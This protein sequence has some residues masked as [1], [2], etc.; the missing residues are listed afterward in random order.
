MT[1]GIGNPVFVVQVDHGGGFRMLSLNRSHEEA[2]GLSHVRMSGRPLNEVLPSEVVE[3]VT[4]HYQQCVERRDR[5]V[6]EELLVLPSGR[7]WWKTV[8]TPVLDEV[9]QVCRL[10]GSGTEVTELRHAEERYRALFEPNPDAVYVIDAESRFHACNPATER[11]SGYPRDE[12]LGKSFLDLVPKE[13]HER[14]VEAFAAV[15]GG[16]SFSLPLR[17]YRPDGELRYIDVTAA[18]YAMDGEVMGVMSIARDATDRIRLEEALKDS[19]RH[20]RTIADNLPIMITHFD[21]EECYTFNNHLYETA[22]NIPPDAMVGR[23]IEEIVPPAQYRQ[24]QPYIRRALEGEQ[25]SV[26]LEVELDTVGRREVEVTYLPDITEDGVLRGAFGM[27][28]DIS[29]RKSR[30]RLLTD[31]ATRDELTG[32]LNRAGLLQRLRRRTHEAPEQVNALL[33]L[34]LD[35]FKPVNDTYGHSAGDRLLRIIAERL[36]GAVRVGDDVARL[37]GDE[38]V[39]LLSGVHDEAQVAAIAQQ[40]LALMRQPVALEV[41]TVQVS[42]SMGGVISSLAKTTPEQLLK[43]ADQAMYSAKRKGKNGFCLGSDDALSPSDRSR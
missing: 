24:L 17:F 31:R 12:L 22:F 13:D 23:R 39:V 34:D 32:L 38:F 33:F 8:L 10:L 11:I 29:L 7:R 25:V 42:A 35:D 26:E 2:S 16:R 3:Q 6:Y 1:D 19:E 20:L 9:G 15:L 27:I 40:L 37:G 14:V 43:I 18:P 36:R 41:A 21:T 5:Y 30:E 4:G 28:Q